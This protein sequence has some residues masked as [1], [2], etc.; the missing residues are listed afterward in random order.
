M[1]SYNP[2][3]HVRQGNHSYV[4]VLGSAISDYSSIHRDMKSDLRTGFFFFVFFLLVFSPRTGDRRTTYPLGFTVKSTLRKGRGGIASRRLPRAQA[5]YVV[6][7]SFPQLHG[8]EETAVD[9]DPMEETKYRWR[10][11]TKEVRKS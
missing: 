2:R 5:V 6:A 3:H 1:L 8:A 9:L 4:S 11:R 7:C 10:H